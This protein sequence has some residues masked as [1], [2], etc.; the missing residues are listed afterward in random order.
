MITGAEDE[1]FTF[2]VYTF[3]MELLVPGL[4]DAEFSSMANILAKNDKDGNPMNEAVIPGLLGIIDGLLFGIFEHEC[5]ATATFT[6]EATATHDGYKGTYCKDNG[7]YVKVSVIEAT[8]TTEPP[9]TEPPVTEPPVTEPPVTEP[10]ADDVLLGDVNKDGKV[11]AI[12][13]RKILRVGAQLEKFDDESLNAVADVNKDGKVNAI[14][15]RKVL[16]VGAQLETF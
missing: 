14:D 12:D 2:D 11:N 4:Y 1:T 15:A 3:V 8:G 7:H 13:A 10:P 16:R 6:K 9:V 5:G